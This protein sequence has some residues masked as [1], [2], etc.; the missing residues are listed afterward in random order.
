DMG[1]YN[2]RERMNVRTLSIDLDLLRRTKLNNVSG[3]CTYTAPASDTNDDN[4]SCWL[5]LPT[6]IEAAGGA[7]H[8]TGLIYAFRE[9][10]V[11]E[12]AIARPTRADAS[13][14]TCDADDTVGTG[15]DDKWAQVWNTYVTNVTDGNSDSTIDIL[16]SNGSGLD[17]FDMVMDAVGLTGYFDPPVDPCTKISPKPVDFYNDPDRRPHGF[18]LRNGQDLRR[19]NTAG[20]TFDTDYR[21]MSFVSDNPVYVWGNLNLHSSDGTFTNRIEEFSTLLTSNWSNFYSRNTLN[22]NFATG[23]NDTWRQTE[24]ISDAVTTLSSNFNPGFI[25]EGLLWS[26]DSGSTVNSYGGMGIPRTIANPTT[27][28]HQNSEQA[29]T[30][31]TDSDSTADSV[32]TNC[33]T[34]D[35]ASTKRLGRQCWLLEDGTQVGTTAL[36]NVASPIALNRNGFPLYQAN[37]TTYAYA[38]STTRSTEHFEEVGA[39]AASGDL[40]RLTRSRIPRVSATDNMVNAVIVSGISPGRINQK[41]GGIVN[42]LRFN[43]SWDTDPS[44][45]ATKKDLRFA[46]SLY[47]LNFS[48]YSGGFDQITWEPGEVNANDFGELYY[49]SPTLNYGYDPALLYVPAG[50]VARRFTTPGRTR[51]EFY[52][53]LAVDDPYILNLRCAYKADG[54]TRVDPNVDTTLCSN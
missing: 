54:V 28:S 43:E 34:E 35:P 5:P 15:D 4:G 2:G 16:A 39:I 9:D 11:R 7:T 42:F 1:L 3:G 32:I 31:G 38:S 44:N 24:I 48:S 25:I 52:R 26:T 21:G 17:P 51:S 29:D 47:Q 49:K 46:G 8:T 37:G 12:D 10:A 19:S 53:E 40:Y 13:G 27:N 45:S 41:N 18:V 36:A 30:S 6:L 22:T 50:P 23:A 33:A 14:L 20:S